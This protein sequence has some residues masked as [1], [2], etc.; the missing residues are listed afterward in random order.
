MIVI[1]GKIPISI[2][3][4]F[5]VVAA[6]I[7]WTFSYTL[8]GTLIWIGIVFISVLIHEFGHALT[9]LLFRQKT[10]I[11]LV[12]LGGLTSYEGPR[13][14][15]WQQFLITFN[16]PL[17]G[18]FLFLGATFLLSLHV[19][20]PPF[21]AI[22]RAIQVANL[23]WTVV[24]LLP[25]LP[26]DGGQLLRIALEAAFGVKGFKASLLI[27]AIL[28][29]VLA[30]GCFVIR[31][32]LAGAIFFLFAFESFDAWRK[33]RFVK[34]ED[35]DDLLQGEMIKGEKALKEGKKEEARAFFE[36]ILKKGDEGV[37]A[38]GAAHYLAF[39]D[40]EEGDHKK[41]YERLFALQDRLSPEGLPLL[42]RLAE[43]AENY[44]LIARLSSDC[45]QLQATQEVAL[46]NAR[47]FAHLGQAKPA[48][49]WLQTAW[50]YGGLELDALLGESAFAS[51]QQAP[52]FQE[53]VRDM[54]R[55]LR[56]QDA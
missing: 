51:L 40:E 36:E 28:A 25:I 12:A 5:W 13:L 44:A 54:R 47:A 26:M 16:G 35:R 19:A 37:F 52:E 22:L 10:E 56:G 20:T 43:K 24:N 38:T 2:H 18:F 1:P 14:R 29:T 32:F 4:L 34:K 41:A 53:F 17:F 8:V 50:Q 6:L 45:Y 23:F 55:T 33:S 21:T 15:F 31:A 11:R 39:L 30:L 27:G 7:G 46:R 48:G 42:H 49:G 9:A 3:P